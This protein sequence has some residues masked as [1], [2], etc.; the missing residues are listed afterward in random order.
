MSYHDS[1]IQPT[2][3]RFGARSKNNYHDDL[4]FWV[5]RANSFKTLLTEASEHLDD[6]E[7]LLNKIKTLGIQRA[8]VDDKH[9]EN[10]QK[11]LRTIKQEIETK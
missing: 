1:H 5:S 3:Q 2:V 8:D 7:S 6:F 4:D 9:L 10:L 11:F